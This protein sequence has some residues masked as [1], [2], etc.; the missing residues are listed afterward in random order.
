MGITAAEICIYHVW[1]WVKL[2]PSLPTLTEV[3]VACGVHRIDWEAIDNAL[4]P[5]GDTS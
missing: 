5:V 4:N 1:K 2:S 3:C